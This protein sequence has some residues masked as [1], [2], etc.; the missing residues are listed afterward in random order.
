[1]KYILK[2]DRE[3]SLYKKFGFLLLWALLMASLPAQS[4]QQL[5]YKKI[6]LQRTNGTIQDFL[7]DLHQHYQ[8][9]FSYDEHILPQK[10]FK[11]YKKSWKLQDLLQKLGQQAQLKV[12]YV[13]GQVILKKWKKVKVSGTI[14]GQNDNEYLLGA[15]V[16]VPEL[17]I[18][19]VSDARGRYQ[20]LIPSGNYTSVFSYIGHQSIYQPLK[21]QEN[22][23]LDVKLRPQADVLGEVVIRSFRDASIAQLTSDQT[24]KHIL[25]IENIKQIPTLAGE[26][27]VLKSLQRMPGTQNAAVGTTNFSVRGGSYDQNLILLDG[28]PL[29]NTGHTAGFFSVINPDIIQSVHFYKGAL[30]AKYGGRLSSV[31][32]I[33][34]HD[35]APKK[36]QI[37][38]GVGLISSRL[39]VEAPLGKKASF[40]IAG[41]QG[42]PSEVVHLLD[43]HRTT[44]TGS[45]QDFSGDYFAQ[46][47]DLYAKF[48]FRLN[49]SN[50]LSITTFRVQDEF[51]NRIG[52]WLHNNK[53]RW[54]NLGGAITWNHQYNKQLNSQLRLIYSDI[55]YQDEYN[56]AF[57]LTTD[58]WTSGF[59]Q[60][61]LTLDFDYE[62][63]PTS[64]FN[65][66]ISG[67]RHYFKS[68]EFKEDITSHTSNLPAKQA[69]EVGLYMDHQLSLGN[70]WSF[71]YGLRLSGFYNFGEGVRYV[72]GPNQQLAHTTQFGSGQVIDRFYGIEPKL[73]VRYLLNQHSSLR[74]SYNRSYQY[75][76]QLSNSL[77]SL[78]SDV[79]IPANNNIKP[80]FADQLTLG[81]FYRFG[82]KKQF[83]LSS[84]IYYKQTHRTIDYQDNAQLFFNRNVETQLR[85][86]QDKSHGLELMLAKNTGKL[87]GWIGYTWSKTERQIPGIN[88]DQVFM[89]SFDRRHNLSLTM[90][91]ALGKR[92]VIS[93]NYSYM[94]GTRV[95][96]PQ[97]QF[98]V[99]NRTYNFYTDRNGYQ[100]PNFHQWDLSL[101]L[102]SKKRKKWQGEWIF[103][104]TNV[105]NQ[106]NPTAVSLTKSV[107]FHP[108]ISSHSLV[109][110]YLFG[111]VPSITYNFKF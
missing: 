68:A 52:G 8:I 58:Q 30:P 103:G 87:T 92:W 45:S 101:T 26:A 34:S 82:Q 4:Q 35:Q 21:A 76:H 71:R 18:G 108:K 14:K 32:S 44:I 89:P 31:V 102:K 73:S 81:H 46:F 88:N 12:K 10:T 42:Y 85:F 75:L 105:Y 6:Q 50:Q 59:Q 86:G 22:I 25:P 110:S 47:Q 17:N 100:L 13:N 36:L 56:T 33:E 2:P 55:N 40:I 7:K 49:T 28:I 80:R 5:R 83:S 61:G 67:H 91:Y 79:W 37:R 24:D 62:T 38:G 94:S 95:T 1:M 63:S 96:L 53:Y 93:S 60:V 84:E 27:D 43:L 107:P 64:K 57:N 97:G 99:N 104:V 66:G 23:S 20:L 15:T 3:Y 69:L 39:A 77:V 98:V 54:N 78:P 70:K 48:N 9:N 19:S 72:Y 16:Y 11:L 106:K 51:L 90:S 74:F 111:W 41:R 109:K 29:Y 65:F